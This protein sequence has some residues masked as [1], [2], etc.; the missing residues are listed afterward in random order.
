MME[1]FTALDFL[2]IAALPNEPTFWGW[3][4]ETWTAVGMGGATI[5]ALTV[6]IAG[7][8]RFRH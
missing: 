6:S 1:F 4:S 7:A 5:V 8:L 2:R 3:D